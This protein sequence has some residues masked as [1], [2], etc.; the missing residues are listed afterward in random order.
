Y[1]ENED[2]PLWS[3]VCTPDQREVYDVTALILLL[4]RGHSGSALRLRVHYRTH[5]HL[6][7]VGGRIDSPAV[8]VVQRSG[9]SIRVR[10]IAEMRGE[11]T[12]VIAIHRDRRGQRSWPVRSRN[13]PRRGQHV[14][15]HLGNVAEPVVIKRS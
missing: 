14:T 7:A 8:I 4:Q 12:L 3:G 13:A 1:P 10:S 11:G 15:L 5:V 2:L 6:Q 9:Y